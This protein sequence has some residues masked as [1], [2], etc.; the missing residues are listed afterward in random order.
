M[1]GWHIVSAKSKLAHYFLCGTCLCNVGYRPLTGATNEDRC[2]RCLTLAKGGWRKSKN[3]KLH[4]MQNGKVVCGK[5]IFHKYTS[6][7]NLY[8]KCTD[9]KRMVGKD[10]I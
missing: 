3:G 9:C 2:T 1:N 5:R 7:P 8:T 10:Q 4:H 6:R